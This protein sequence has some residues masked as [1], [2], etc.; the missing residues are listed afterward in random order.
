MHSL[1]S[2]CMYTVLASFAVMHVLSHRDFTLCHN[3]WVMSRFCRVLT[4]NV[5]DE[6]TEMCKRNVRDVMIARHK[7]NE[8]KAEE[9]GD[10]G[11][12]SL[13][14]STH[15]NEK[16]TIHA[17]KGRGVEN[18]RGVVVATVVWQHAVSPQM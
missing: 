13:N 11:G 3:T 15:K 14:D 17:L 16:S 6:W 8:K 9:R 12:S 1:S 5:Q 4:I 18:N 7:K 2:P 10:M